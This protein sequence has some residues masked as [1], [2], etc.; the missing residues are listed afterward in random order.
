VTFCIPNYEQIATYHDTGLNEPRPLKASLRSFHALAMTDPVGG[1]WVY[2][3]LQ[4]KRTIGQ[5]MKMIVGN[6]KDSQKPTRRSAYTI[7][8]EPV[9]EPQLIKK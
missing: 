5:I 2:C 8:I 4:A 3:F 6:K 9:R 1:E 7:A